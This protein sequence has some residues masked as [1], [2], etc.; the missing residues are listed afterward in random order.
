M[1][2]IS[3]EDS[4]LFDLIFAAVSFFSTVCFFKFEG[5]MG[6]FAEKRHLLVDLS[7]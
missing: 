6:S 7:F 5:R 4:I 2:V 3:A 1:G